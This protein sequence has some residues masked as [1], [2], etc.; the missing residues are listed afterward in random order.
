MRVF[1]VAAGNG[2]VGNV[3]VTIASVELVRAN[4]GRYRTREL[5]IRVTTKDANAPIVATI[6]GS[7]SRYVVDVEVS[8]ELDG[9]APGVA[10]VAVAHDAVAVDRSDDAVPRRVE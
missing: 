1:E 7:R 6:Q 8:A 9:E 4:C 5:R 10:S 3:G 2:I